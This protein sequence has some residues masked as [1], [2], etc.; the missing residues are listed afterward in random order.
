MGVTKME[1]VMERVKG[2]G[3]S[4]GVEG[5]GEVEGDWERSRD[6]GGEISR[7]LAL[8]T[9]GSGRCAA[10]RRNAAIFANCVHDFA[11]L[12]RLCSCGTALLCARLST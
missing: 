2:R 3:W 7:D 6:V 8:A 9:S 1:M 10:R 5:R 12:A 11:P 4:R